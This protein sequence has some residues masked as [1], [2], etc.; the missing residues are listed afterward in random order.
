MELIRSYS[1]LE[2]NG[3]SFIEMEAEK[4]YALTPKG[5]FVYNENG[6][7]KYVVSGEEIR[8][9]S[10][11]PLKEDIT[12][13]ALSPNGETIACGG[14]KKIMLFDISEGKFENI[15]EHEGWVKC[16]AFSPDGK[17]LASGSADNTV[18]VWD[19]ENKTLVKTLDWYS[20]PIQSVAFNKDGSLLATIDDRGGIK[21]YNTRNWM[22]QNVFR[23]EVDR[24]EFDD[25]GNLKVVP[26]LDREALTAPIFNTNV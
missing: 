11:F 7:Y 21:T 15:G 19:M 25:L 12:V 18:K 26:K 2:F 23:F 16:L 1:C 8:C 22:F 20:R 5:I 4:A 13:M 10:V 24:L 3:C 14:Y 17:I 9:S 6:I